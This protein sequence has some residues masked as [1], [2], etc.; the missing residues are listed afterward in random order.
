[1]K[2]GILSSDR[3]EWHVL[4]LREEL[5]K[6]KH[7][8][9]VFPISDLV[10]RIGLDPKMSIK[11]YPVDSYDA[12]IVR[13]VPGGSVEQIF[14]RMDTLHMLEEYGVVV[15]N[16]PESI[17]KSVNKYYT[18][19]LLHK[20][21]L[22]SPRT[23]V[24]ENFREAIRGFRELGEDVILKP[25]FG[26]LGS[27]ITRITDPEIAYRVFRSLEAINSVFYLQE[28]IPHDNT[29]IRIFVIGGEVVSAMKRVGKNWKTNISSGGEPMPYTPSN[30]EKEYSIKA[31]EILG[32]DY[33]G[34]DL[35]PSEKGDLYTIEVNSTP[36]WEGLQNVTS[37]NISEHIINY[38][39]SKL[40]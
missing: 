2:I 20:Y 27:G 22:N 31:A 1:M 36:G 35:L 32:L 4:R 5:K 19:A 34:V 16:S 6:R 38:I 25:I 28:Y 30:E 37:K 21:G 26:S 18:S 24:A 14:Y 10:S 40:K 29:D 3:R 12:I 39:S 17:E 23:I 8:I 15:F 11:G 7:E 9:Y 33:T 13:R